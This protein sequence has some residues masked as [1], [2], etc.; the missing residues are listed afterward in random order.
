MHTYLITWNPKRFD[1]ST[2]RVD[3]QNIRKKGFLDGSWSCGN[4]KSIEQGDR[5]YLLRQGI[6]PRGIMGFGVATS[7]PY[8]RGHWDR[9][10]RGESARF[11]G[12]RFDALLDPIEEGILSLEQLRR[13][14]PSVHWNTQAS[15]ISISPEAAGQ[16]ER[17]WVA[18][19]KSCGQSATE[20]AEEIAT[21]QM[22]F[23]GAT[24][25]ISV[26]AYER[27]PRARAACIKHYGISCYVCGMEFSTA[28]GPLGE[29]FIHVHHILPLSK[30]GKRYQIDPVRHLRPVCPNCHSMLHRQPDSVIPVE[31]LRKIVQE[32]RAQNERGQ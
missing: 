4:T 1:W 2:L 3:L 9:G 19:L 10:R 15:G 27:D 23:E 14:L 20:L 18:L 22:F 6:E 28:Y 17:L 16:I 5:V 31:K 29:G 25:I 8:E 7:S 30:I 12:V 32:H 11:I 26:N 21:P 24:R 13:A